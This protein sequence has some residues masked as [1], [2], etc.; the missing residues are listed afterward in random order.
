MKAFSSKVLRKEENGLIGG[1][2][3]GIEV[4][5]QE[6]DMED[7]HVKG[8]K[9]EGQRLKLDEVFNE[10]ERSGDDFFKKGLLTSLF[11]SVLNKFKSGASLE[12][13]LSF[14][15]EKYSL[16]REGKTE[17]LLELIVVVI[18]IKDSDK[19][20]GLNS[21]RAV[22]GSLI[23]KEERVLSVGASRDK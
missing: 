8:L 9:Q 22:E 17:I 1:L 7:E 11:S 4:Q 3:N 16:L 6:E 12:R 23:M 19:K 20:E 2:E 21:G 10:E 18:S 5:I 15:M 13:L 14:K